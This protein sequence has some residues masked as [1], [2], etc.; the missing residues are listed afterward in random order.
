MTI[1]QLH[2][3]FL[4][5]LT[6]EVI[7]SRRQQGTLDYYRRQLRPLINAL[8][9]REIDSLIPYDLV[10]LPRTWHRVQAVQRLFA[11]GC[12]VG[13][14]TTNPFRGIERPQPGARDRVL[15]RLEL[16]RLLRS[17]SRQARKVLAAMRH[18]LARPQ[19]VRALTWPMLRE[20]LAA[21]VLADFK[22]RSRRRDGLRLRLIALDGWMMRMLRRW[23]S[24]STLAH[25]FINSRGRPWTSNAL[26]LAVARARRLAGLDQGGEDV[27]PYTLRHTAATWATAAGVRDRVLADLLGH[28][29]TRTTA[30][31]QHLQPHHLAD[32]I[33]QATGK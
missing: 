6:L 32:A 14:I 24:R 19:E 29:N 12:Q 18:T 20:D 31:Y 2:G 22:G 17:S 11:W 13:L 8:G 16:A 5:Y 15:S 1:A 25:V 30:R 10:E 28:A 26:R 4:H 23:R 27:V 3:K 7:A 33:H 21:F 9:E